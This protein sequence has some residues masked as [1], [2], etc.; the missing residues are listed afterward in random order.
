MEY[1]KYFLGT[2]S[3]QIQGVLWDRENRMKNA[4]KRYEK[5]SKGFGWKMLAPKRLVFLHEPVD[6]EQFESSKMIFVLW[7]VFCLQW[8]FSGQL[9]KSS[10][11]GSEHTHSCWMLWVLRQLFFIRNL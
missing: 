10:I 11:P 2:F 9:L 6:H 1:L 4:M 7:G 8:F 3:K 5:M